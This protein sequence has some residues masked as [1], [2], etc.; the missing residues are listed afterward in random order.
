[1]GKLTINFTIFNSKPLNDQRVDGTVR[2]FCKIHLRYLMHPYAM[3][4][5][6][7]GR[8][9]SRM[10]AQ[11]G[12]CGH[13]ASASM[14]CRERMWQPGLHRWFFEMISSNGWVMFRGLLNRTFHHPMAAQLADSPCLLGWCP[15]QAKGQKFNSSNLWPNTLKMIRAKYAADFENF[16]YTCQRCPNWAGLR[17]SWPSGL[18][19][20]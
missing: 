7:H 4:L 12:Y 17:L 10:M 15:L 19:A 20:H 9:C 6:C 18:T 3:V 13:M 8:L 11:P 5:L 2:W 14:V 16:N 1:M